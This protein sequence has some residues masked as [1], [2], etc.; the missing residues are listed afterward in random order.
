MSESESNYKLT[1]NCTLKSTP[2]TRFRKL[3]RNFVTTRQK[4]KRYWI[5]T[6]IYHITRYVLQLLLMASRSLVLVT[7]SS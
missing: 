1:R 5:G 4:G 7:M 3:K 2:S 6:K